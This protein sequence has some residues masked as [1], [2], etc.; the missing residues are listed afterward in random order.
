MKAIISD[1]Y[2]TY[3]N[4]NLENE[5]PEP[6]V[7][8]LS[9]RK[10]LV[11]TLSVA[12]APGDTRVLSGDCKIAQGPPSF[13]YVPGG[14]LCGIIADMNGVDPSV[15]GYDVGDRV[16]ARFTEGP[17][18]ALGEYAVITASMTGKVPDNVS[19]EDAA[20]LASSATIA[21]A[22]SKR[23]DPKERV[24]IMGAGGGVGSHL[25]QF[26]KMKGVEYV[27]GVSREPGRLLSKPLSYDS[28]L[29]YTQKDVWDFREWNKNNVNEK[30]DT[31]VDLAGGGWLRLLEQS[32]NSSGDGSD[33]MIV[34][35][36]S[37]GG[38]YL[39][40]TMDEAY[41]KSDSIWGL[42][43]L[44]LFVPMFRALYSRSTRRTKLPSYTFAHS[45]FNDVEIM[46]E[47]LQLASENKL[48]AC[49]DDRGPFTF[50]TEGA[51]DAFQ[52]LANRH[53][54]GKVVIKIADDEVGP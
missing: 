36:A 18:G 44:F 19:S 28:A 35:P 40:L 1:D 6:H 26:L 48:K 29:D 27:A 23:I 11:K 9:K 52:L 8:L 37:E 47:T 14:D 12:L 10:M 31:I 3:K 32:N 21:C 41:F 25:C 24:V 15:V 50:S 2:G 17:R 46:K 13:P 53:V 34:K 16:A 51:Q 43:K 42:L 30:F 33:E 54:R 4:L 22:L 39:T 5:F 7:E 20:A 38:R 45:L 49:I